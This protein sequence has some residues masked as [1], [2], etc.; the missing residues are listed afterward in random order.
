MKGKKTTLSARS[1]ELN[2]AN[3]FRAVARSIESAL[4]TN[5]TST[6]FVSLFPLIITLALS[7]A[8]TLMAKDL[9][10][11][12]LQ[13]AA[14]LS[15]I[16]IITVL[17]AWIRSLLAAVVLLQLSDQQK[18]T[19]LR[20]LYTRE[21][22]PYVGRFFSIAIIIVVA[23]ILVGI[24]LLRALAFLDGSWQLAIWLILYPGLVLYMLSKSV[25]AFF[26]IV[27]TNASLGN[28]FQQSIALS[29]GHS[30]SIIGSLL[31]GGLTSGTGLLSSVGFVGGLHTRYLAYGSA[32]KP[33][34][35]KQLHYLD[36]ILLGLVIVVCITAGVVTY[37]ATRNS[38][39]ISYSPNQQTEVEKTENF[40]YYDTRSSRFDCSKDQSTC[41]KIVD[42]KSTLDARGELDNLLELPLN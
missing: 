6:L 37:F 14:V 19:N 13:L 15:F 40:C 7:V 10:V 29:R 31:A 38:N 30:I 41:E 23:L 35:R 8:L 42:C 5:P 26:S 36:W 28:A 4:G 25:L 20:A 39:N 11:Q 33:T 16:A 21:S 9:T 34:N 32:Q 3:P 24:T 17:V 12:N 18:S 2:P 27:H 22:R 1:G